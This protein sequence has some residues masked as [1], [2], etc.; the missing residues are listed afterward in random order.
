MPLYLQEKTRIIG[1]HPNR[2]L[3]AKSLVDYVLAD[4]SRESSPLRNIGIWEFVGMTGSWSQVLGL[5]EFPDGWNH[6]TEMIGQTMKAPPPELA[7]T[8]AAVQNLRSG[9]EDEILAPLP[10]CPSRADL[11][12]TGTG[13]A[14][15]VHDDVRVDPGREDDYAATLMADFA[16]IAQAHAHRLIGL[17]RGALTDG[18]MIAYWATS[19]DGY[20][21]LMASP[22]TRQWHNHARA[23]RL[24]WRQELWTAAPRSRFSDASVD[25]GDRD[26]RAQ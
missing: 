14:L 18:L 5:Y 22:A 4:A 20:R 6:L 21:A 15:L 11:I 3:F 2:R 26:I 10:G 23:E 7:A 12:A 24:A 19:F 25:Y 16:P 8:Y 17:Y 1:M 9:G 13:G